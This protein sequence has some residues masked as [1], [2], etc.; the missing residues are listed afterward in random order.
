[1]IILKT[2]KHI[3]GTRRACRL[4]AEFLELVEKLAG[5]GI[6]TKE[7]D[8]LATEFAQDNSAL[9]AF[10]GYQGFPCSICAS[11]NNEVIHGIP[12]NRPLQEGDILSVDYGILLD[13]Y[14]G[15]SAITIPIGKV[16]KK[17]ERLIKTGQEC[18]YHGIN[19]FCE[20][21]RL[22]DISYAVQSH[23]NNNGYNI[24]KSYGGHGVGKV[25][26][27]DPQLPN[28]TRRP[29]EGVALQR[30][31][32][33]AIEPMIMAG[34]TETVKDKNNWTV[35]SKDGK[36]SVHW[37]H[38]TALTEKGVEILTQRITEKLN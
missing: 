2:Y 26:H 20:G 11:V 24:L 33:L 9:P 17:I 3:E 19:K 30:G 7:L 27:E 18:L 34:N 38:T 12:S 1:M 6:T 14:Y 23:A 22:S 8:K 37:E 5:P 31:M 16:S 4:V 21:N 29:G 28:F 32:I 10:K 36:L 15:D 13:G 25:L 35:L